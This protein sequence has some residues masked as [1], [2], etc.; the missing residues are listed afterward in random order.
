MVMVSSTLRSCTRRTLQAVLRS[1]NEHVLST[2]RAFPASSQKRVSDF[3]T[4]PAE[5]TVPVNPLNVAAASS[6]LR[7]PSL[8]HVVI[9]S[10][11]RSLAA[12][13]G[14]FA[15]RVDISE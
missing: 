12:Y 6:C 10:A 3:A 13:A 2:T 11:R 7:I 15:S 9:N 5:V 1:L 8:Q 4:C 14:S